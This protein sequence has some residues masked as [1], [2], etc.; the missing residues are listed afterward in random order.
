MG[1]EDFSTTDTP[2][3]WTIVAGVVTTNIARESSIVYRGTYALKFIDTGIA[4]ITIKQSIPE[5][6]LV[7][8]QRYC[9]SFRYRA[10]AADGAGVDLTVKFTGTGYTEG[11]TEKSVINGVAFPTSYTLAYFFVTMPEVI[12]SDF[13]LNVTLTGT[14]TEIFYLDDFGLAPVTYHNGLAFVVIAGATPFVKRD[15]FTADVSMTD[16]VIQRFMIRNYGTMLPSSAAA[17]T[18]SDNL[19]T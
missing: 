3:G 14:P 7:P 4:A 18:I 13:G 8:L 16:G 1:F 11:T 12:P 15:L 19:A 2:D 9:C 6:Q 17:P 10:A 5:S